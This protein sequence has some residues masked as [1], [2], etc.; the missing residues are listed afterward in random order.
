M[1]FKSKRLALFVLLLSIFQCAEASKWEMDQH[2]PHRTILSDDSLMF[3]LVFLR[4]APYNTD[5]SL[6]IAVIRGALP[7]QC[8]NGFYPSGS[9]KPIN[10][11][12]LLIN[13]TYV[14]A[15]AK[16]LPDGV[17]Y[18]ITTE[19]GRSFID[20]LAKESK[21]ITVKIPDDKEI[22]FTNDDGGKFYQEIDNKYG[23]I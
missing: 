12:P 11:P 19:E 2:G 4:N 16:C 7:S 21:R 5:S 14:K 9:S 22:I 13:E 17:S 8:S 23:G 6:M 20:R 1:E 15:M 18:V 3:H 10:I